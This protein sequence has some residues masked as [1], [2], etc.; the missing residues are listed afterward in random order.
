MYIS[1]QLVRLCELKCKDEGPGQQVFLAEKK[2]P[3]NKIAENQGE[4]F[5]NY[6]ESLQKT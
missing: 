6:V 2:T 3:N 4:Q 1:K 5:G